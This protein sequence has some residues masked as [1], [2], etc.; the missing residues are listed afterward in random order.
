MN[1]IIQKLLDLVSR[2][3]IFNISDIAHKAESPR[4]LSL[5][6]YIRY[7]KVHSLTEMSQNGLNSFKKSQRSTRAC[8]NF[9]Q[10]SP[11]WR[12]LAG[13][14]ARS[15]TLRIFRR[16]LAGKK[17]KRRFEGGREGGRQ[18]IAKGGMDI[19]RNLLFVR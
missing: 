1:P 13:L 10:V 5:S 17:R 14:N 6:S 3:N 11:P 12:H 19:H 2:G 18:A 9:A 4:K 16:R 15:R 8:V 7:G